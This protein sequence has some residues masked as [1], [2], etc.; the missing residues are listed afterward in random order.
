MPARKGVRTRKPQKNSK[1]QP[2]TKARKRNLIGTKKLSEKKIIV[3][4]A[5]QEKA[6]REKSARIGRAQGKKQQIAR[7]RDAVK[8]LRVKKADRGKLLFISVNGKRNPHHK[9]ITRKGYLVYVTKNGTKKLVKQ[10]K[11]GYKATSF[12]NLRLPL[13]PHLAKQRE[14]ILLARRKLNLKKR[15]LRPKAHGT[16]IPDDPKHSWASDV[17]EKFFGVVEDYLETQR[18]EKTFLLSIAIKAREIPQILTVV[19]DVDGH[20]FERLETYEDQ[21]DWLMRTFWADISSKL[22]SYGFVSSGSAA[23]IKALRR[24]HGKPMDQ[25]EVKDG[26]L[27]DRRHK[28]IITI[29]AFEWKIEA[30]KFHRK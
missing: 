30:V 10:N 25:W 18:T 3:G 11:Y 7:A 26:G 4:L 29:E 8:K 27:W 12:P 15:V 23:H 16:I 17:V 9:K 5:K 2:K 6:N 24:N 28:D 1:R 20:D 19:I 13:N 22:A 14:K 21:A